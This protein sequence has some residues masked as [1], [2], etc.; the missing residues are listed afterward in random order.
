MAAALTRPQAVRPRWSRLLSHKWATRPPT[1]PPQPGSR[2]RPR[3]RPSTAVRTWPPPPAPHAGGSAGNCMRL[4]IAMKP[5]AFPCVR[6]PF[7]STDFS[8]RGI[9]CRDSQVL[10]PVLREETL[11]KSSGGPFAAT[12][13]LLQGESSL[14]T[15][16]SNLTS[17][18]SLNDRGAIHWSPIRLRAHSAHRANRRTSQPHRSAFRAPGP[19][20]C[21]AALSDL[22]RPCSLYGCLH[23]SSG[24]VGWMSDGRVAS[25]TV[26]HR[27]GC[28]RCTRSHGCSR[29]TV[30]PS[31]S[32]V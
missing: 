14:A 3:P 11:L 25:P 30:Q 31:A 4:A 18:R 12:G 19:K 17:H 13:E 26:Q 2:P 28:E 9:E 21:T 22:D 24:R 27:P 10:V 5:T 7:V 1:D 15:R 16:I 6:L 29:C 32:R 20:T 23:N 8:D